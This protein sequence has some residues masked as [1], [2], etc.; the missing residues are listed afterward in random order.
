M[1]QADVFWVDNDM[2]FTLSGVQ[3]STAAST[4]FINSSTGVTLALWKAESTA[5]TTNLITIGGAASVNI[6]YITASSGDYAVTV[7]STSVT[8]AVND[9]GVAI[10]TV[11]HSGIDGK[12]YKSWRADY[13]RAT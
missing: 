11:S 3:S 13:R 6:P 12:W 5:S 9:A 4:S 7:E 1:A 8:I 2:R 10:F